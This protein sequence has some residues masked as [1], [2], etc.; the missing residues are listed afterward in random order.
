MKKTII[1]VG[2][3]AMLVTGVLGAQTPAP[4]PPAVVVPQDE[5][6]TAWIQQ[7]QLAAELANSACLQTVEAKRYTSLRNEV[8]KKVESRVPGF[9]V[10]WTTGKLAPKK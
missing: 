1:G 3:V 4:A 9:T 2:V 5:L 8:I 6:V 10:D 7:A